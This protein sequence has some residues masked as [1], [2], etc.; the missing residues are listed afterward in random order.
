[1]VQMKEPYDFR[2]FFK[3]FFAYIKIYIYTCIVKF[4]SQDE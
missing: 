1:M 3:I 2:K 4:V